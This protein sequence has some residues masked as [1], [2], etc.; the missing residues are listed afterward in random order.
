MRRITAKAELDIAG[1]V[2]IAE[3]VKTLSHNTWPVDETLIE[4][5]EFEEIA[6]TSTLRVILIV[7]GESYAQ[8]EIIAENFLRS[9][10]AYIS[11][12]LQPSF[13]QPID[14][15]EGSMLLMRA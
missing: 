10:D 11:S 3:L 1:P 14:V 8:A 4:N 9:I 15:Q 5:I 2:S 7:H 13:T 12:I 6:N